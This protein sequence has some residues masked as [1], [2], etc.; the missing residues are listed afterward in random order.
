VPVALAVAGGTHGI[1]RRGE[2]PRGAEGGGG[3]DPHRLGVLL[4]I[5]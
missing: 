3:H 4:V 1:V 5:A 2:H